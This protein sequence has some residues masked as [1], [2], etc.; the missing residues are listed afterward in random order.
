MGGIFYPDADVNEAQNV[1]L[2]RAHLVIHYASNCKVGHP[3]R[4]KGSDFFRALNNMTQAFFFVRSRLAF[5]TERYWVNPPGLSSSRRSA[6][7]APL[8][9]GGKR[10]LGTVTA[11]TASLCLRS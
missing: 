8:A 5:L 4:S 7:L 3:E 9:G 6:T 11:L 2:R 10:R 1:E